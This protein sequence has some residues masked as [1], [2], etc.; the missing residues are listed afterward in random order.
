MCKEHK[1][2]QVHIRQEIAEIKPSHIKV[3]KGAHIRVR[4]VFHGDISLEKAMGNLVQ[5]R[6][7]E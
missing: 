6:I 1:A 5:R 3:I 7:S 4:S 2:E